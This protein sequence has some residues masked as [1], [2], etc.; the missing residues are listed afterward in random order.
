MYMH[1][2]AA[3]FKSAATPFGYRVVIPARRNGFLLVFMLAWFG[4]WVFGEVSA[5]GQLLSAGSKAPTGFLSFWLVG[6]TVGGLFVASTILWQ[7][8]GREVI[9]VDSESVS[10]RVE[11]LGVGRT[12]DF[13]LS[14]VKNLR[15]A[16][17]VEFSLYRQRV[18]YPPI[19]GSGYGPVA[20]DY[21]A[22]TFK[23]APSLDEAEACQLISEIKS[24]LPK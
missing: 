20:F 1:P 14:H 11:A 23:V 18:S 10:Y 21:G 9:T 3:R 13:L 16:P 6:W 4:G 15:V 24:Y 17:Y 22:R 8:A 19:F 2:Q 5:S 12:R 7:L